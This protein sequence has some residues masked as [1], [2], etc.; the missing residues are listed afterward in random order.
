M[1]KATLRLFP[2]VEMEQYHWDVWN[3]VLMPAINKA[4][5]GFYRKYP[6]SVEISLE[7]IG[8]TAYSTKPTILIVC[9]S[10][11]KVRSILKKHFSYDS[12]IYG[13]MVCRGK[14]FRSR[15]NQSRRSA[16]SDAAGYLQTPENPS[17]QERPL[18]GASIGAYVEG[19]H[20]PPVSFGGLVMVGNKPYGLTVHHMLDDPAVQDQFTMLQEPETKFDIPPLDSEDEPRSDEDGYAVSEHGSDYSEASSDGDYSDADDE[21]VFQAQD[22]G[23]IEGIPEGCGAGYGITQPAL[24]D[25]DE[26]FYPDEETVDQDHLDTYGLGEIY[27]SSGIRRRNQDGIA[28]EIDWALFEFDEQRRPSSNYIKGGEQ[29]CHAR[30]MYP[31]EIAPWSSLHGLEIHCS[32]RTTGLQK[33]RILPGMTIVK[34]FGRQ[35][36]S[37]SYQV[38]GKLGIPGDSG[39]WVIDNAKGRACGHILAWSSRKQVAYIC[40]MEIILADIADTLEAEVSLPSSKVPKIRDANEHNE[41]TGGE[42]SSNAELISSWTKE[43]RIENTKHLASMGYSQKSNDE[44]VDAMHGMHVSHSLVSQS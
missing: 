9:T 30:E 16:A 25:V 39:A 1:P 23:D 43:P 32:G 17:Y 36:P 29:H 28:H 24:D 33:G 20:L 10:V 26:G 14:V 8:E 12:S 37:Q 44:L 22:A 7:R 13:L 31:V 2:A 19:Q 41:L 21:D 42:S 4:L 18:N 5:R 6:E 35:T 15:K 27:A 11:G 34:I 38:S 40:P 3:K